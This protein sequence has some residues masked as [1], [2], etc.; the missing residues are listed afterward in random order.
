MQSE[1]TPNLY[2]F[3]QLAVRGFCQQ[4]WHSYE[5]IAKRHPPSWEP[6]PSISLSARYLACLPKYWARRDHHDW[7]LCTPG[8]ARASLETW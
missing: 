4:L 3:F 2:A 1:E 5:S 7:A 6:R 8:V